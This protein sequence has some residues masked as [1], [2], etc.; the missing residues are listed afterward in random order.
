M[1][2]FFYMFPL[3]L[4]LHCAPPNRSEGKLTTCDSSQQNATPY[5]MSSINANFAFNL[6]WRFTVETTDWNI[7]FSPVSIFS[8]LAMLSLETCHC[9]QTQIINSLEFKLTDTPMTEIQ[10]GFWH[11]ICLLNFPKKELELQVGNTFFI[12][13]QLKPLHSFLDDVKSLYETEVFSTDFSNVSA[14][15]KEI[16]SHVE[17][18]T[19]EKVVGL[20]EDLKPNTMM[21][22]ENYTYFNAQWAN[23]FDPSKT[24]KGSSFSVDKTTIVQVPMMHQME[25]YYHLVDTE[26][27]CAVLQIDYSKSALAL[28]VL[29]REG[30]MEWVEGPMSSETLKK[31]NCLLQ[32]GWIDLFAP[33]FSISA[34]YDLG[35]IFLKI[36]IRDAFADNAN[37][38]EL[39]GDSGL[40][41]SNAAHKAVLH[42]GE[43]GTETVIVPEVRFLYQPEITLLH[44]I[45]K[46]DRSFLLL[47]LKKSTRSILFLGKVVDPTEV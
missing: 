27:N 34:T 39:T 7:F 5:K 47:I 40:Q 43:K 28:F 1:P 14:A 31:W 30:Q 45:I 33:K 38:L 2:L 22:L 12:G 41:L 25:Q 6:Y 15:Q 13:K 36:G 24:E 8:A 11:L 35:A 42:I 37:F 19:K 16:N 20:I 26:L 23:L 21:A 17:K 10:Q 46:F 32:K 4:G 3:V 44:L 29:P 18:Q 9:T